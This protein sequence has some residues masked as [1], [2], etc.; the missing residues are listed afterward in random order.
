MIETKIKKCW[1]KFNPPAPALVGFEV[2]PE[3][4]DDFHQYLGKDLSDHV[5]IL[6]KKIR[7]S[8]SMHNY[9]WVLCDQIAKKRTDF[10]SYTKEDIYRMAVRD[11]G[12]WYDVTLP[13]EQVRQFVTDWS[14]KGEGWFVETII[15]GE[16]V[17]ELR[18]YQGASVYDADA[19]YRLTNYVVEMAKESG[20]ETIPNDELE[21]LKE[22]M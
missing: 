22:M 6:K 1:I 12:L 10:I 2:A 16:E 20:V 21:R 8:R 11:V 3:V 18:A 5:L 19:L 9:M 15:M 4:L 17:T 14:K 13:T 7:K